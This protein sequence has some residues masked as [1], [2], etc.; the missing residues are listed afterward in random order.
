MVHNLSRGC[1]KNRS[2]GNVDATEE[3]Q[4]ED[5]AELFRSIVEKFAPPHGPHLVVPTTPS[6]APTSSTEDRD[7]TVAAAQI[8]GAFQSGL[9]AEQQLEQAKQ[10]F[11][12]VCQAHTH[13]LTAS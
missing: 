13:Y 7:K 10:V 12:H 5:A 3:E 2:K 6:P 4:L 9:P 8:D 11:L 1:G